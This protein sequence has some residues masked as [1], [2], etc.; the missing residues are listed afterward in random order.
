[1]S[2]IY[3]PPTLNNSATV[4]AIFDNSFATQQREAIRRAYPSDQTEVQPLWSKAFVVQLKGFSLYNAIAAT[5]GGVP[6]N[7]GLD[8]ASISQSKTSMPAHVNLNLYSF[9]FLIDPVDHH[10][11]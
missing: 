5:G 4:A 10:A 1:M 2:N 11:S 9:D 8:E 3:V 7:S 6:D